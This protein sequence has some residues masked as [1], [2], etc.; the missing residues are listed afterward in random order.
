VRS[1]AKGVSRLLRLELQQIVSS[2]PGEV[3]KSRQCPASNIATTAFDDRY[4]QRSVRVLNLYRHTAASVAI[5]LNFGR[6]PIWSAGPAP[7]GR[8]NV[9]AVKNVLPPLVDFHGGRAHGGDEH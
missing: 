1:D 4:F 6:S 7:I 2:A 3:A 5:N 9:G 8:S